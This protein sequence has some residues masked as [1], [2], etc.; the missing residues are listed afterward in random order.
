MQKASVSVADVAAIFEARFDEPME[1]ESTQSLSTHSPQEGSL[2]TRP[3]LPEP[4]ANEIQPLSKEEEEN[5]SD[6]ELAEM[7]ADYYSPVIRTDGTT[8]YLKEI[9]LSQAGPQEKQHW[10]QIKSFLRLSA[11]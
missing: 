6:F 10:R 7:V 8:F 11:L 1:S 3:T 4:R 9:L 5:I 2:A